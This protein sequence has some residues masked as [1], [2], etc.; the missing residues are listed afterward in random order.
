MFGSHAISIAEIKEN[1]SPLIAGGCF[2]R[3]G[4]SKLALS[5][6]TRVLFITIRG[7]ARPGQISGGFRLWCTR[8]D[9]SLF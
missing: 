3:S 9:F 5:N 1:A 2:L 8:V 7:Q 4:I 6:W